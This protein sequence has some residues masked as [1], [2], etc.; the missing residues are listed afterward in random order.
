VDTLPLKCATQSLNI[1][2][3]FPQISI[4]LPHKQ[5]STKLINKEIPWAFF[6]GASQGTPTRGGVGGII[7]LSPSH[8]ISFKDGIGPATNNFV[9]L[10]LS[11]LVLMMAQE[12]GVTQIQIFE[13]HF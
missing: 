7:Y 12:R 3:A 9:N 11:N 2:Y 4:S 8:T 1:L 10:W 6:D 5:V 13:T